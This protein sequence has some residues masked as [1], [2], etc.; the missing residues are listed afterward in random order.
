M[1]EEKEACEGSEGMKG[2]SLA[3]WILSLKRL[4]VLLLEDALSSQSSEDS[5]LGLKPVH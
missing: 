3:A 4:W 2:M 1:S 5:N